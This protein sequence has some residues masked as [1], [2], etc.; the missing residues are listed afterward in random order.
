MDSK[1]GLDVVLVP[2]D[3][4]LVDPIRL[5]VRMW[6]DF[7]GVDV[8]VEDLVG[9]VVDFPDVWILPCDETRVNSVDKAVRIGYRDVEFDTGDSTPIAVSDFDSGVHKEVS[10]ITEDRMESVE[11]VDIVVET[12]EI[13]DKLVVESGLDACENSTGIYTTDTVLNKCLTLEIDS[14]RISVV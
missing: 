14:Q 13:D 7:E 12:I 11:V 3:K 8:A 5:V 2:D 9:N 6:I 1:E 4:N 10:E